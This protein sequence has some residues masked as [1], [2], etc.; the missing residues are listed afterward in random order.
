ML[1]SEIDH[2][3]MELDPM[4]PRK[5]PFQVAFGLLDAAAVR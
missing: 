4:F 5:Q 3:E 1:A 2:A